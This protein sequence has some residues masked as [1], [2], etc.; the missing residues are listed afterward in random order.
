MKFL[1]EFKK[2]LDVDKPNVSQLM[3][4]ISQALENEARKWWYMHEGEVDLYD[5]FVERF[6][7]RYWDSNTQRTAKRKIEYGQFYLGGATNRINYATSM[8]GIAME[9]DMNYIEEEFVLKLS[10]HFE[11]TI[12]HAI[13]AQ[14]VNDKTILL[15]I[16]ND[17]DNDDQRQKAK[18]A[19]QSKLPDQSRPTP[20]DNAHPNDPRNRLSGNKELQVSAVQE[21]T[22]PGSSQNEK[23]NDKR[24]HDKK[25]NK[26]KK[27]ILASY[28][29]IDASQ[30]SSENSLLESTPSNTGNSG[31]SK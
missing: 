14:H 21:S 5:D 17:Y 16:L 12:R 8:Y 3:C 23:L 31:N 13:I 27:E 11:R 1:S 28:D 25:I 9:V 4:L 6:Q 24:K 7:A 19:F 22:S 15:K 20:R 10:E 29:G 2:Y 26:H 30:I 18:Q